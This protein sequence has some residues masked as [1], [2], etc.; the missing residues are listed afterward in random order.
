MEGG[1]IQFIR[2]EV[3]ATTFLK[4]SAQSF[5]RPGVWNVEIP[6]SGKGGQHA[7]V[8]QNF[9]DAITGKEKL[10]A[11]SAEGI[12]SVE[13][14]NAMLYSSEI[15]QA[16]ELPLNGKTYERMLK[17]KIRESTFVKKTR[18]ANETDLRKSF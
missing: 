17:R 15:G 2:N 13:L 3:S 8:L 5:G 1:G 6:V 18:K 16:V 4:T 11:A 7:E 9:V 14:G 12:K 10:I